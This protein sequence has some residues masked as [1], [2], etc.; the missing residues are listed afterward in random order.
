MVNRIACFLTCGYTEAGAMQFFLRKINNFFEYKQYLPNRTIKKKGD[1]KNI[2]SSISGLTGKALLT[3]VY[4][5]IE[6]HTRE[7]L[8]CAAIIIEDDLDDKFVGWSADAIDRYIQDIKAT[9]YSKLG[10]EKPIFI[11]YA[12]PEVESWFIADWENG[13]RFLYCNSGLVSDVDTNGRMFFT[14]H[15]K[16]YIEKEI[17]KEYCN[18]IE[19]Y[20]DFGGEYIKLSEQLVNAIQVDSKKYIKKLIG[21]NKEYVEQISNSRYLYYSKKLHGD[22][23]LRNISPEEVVKDCHKYFN[24]IYNEL[25]TL[26]L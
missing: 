18:D 12:A 26:S 23:M 13:F 14:H 8:E 19:K 6:K 9:I 15:L 11:M 17:L 1:S 5:I 24:H 4:S 21:T 7:I 16:G 3:K 25:R 20:G 2:G 22:R 10:C